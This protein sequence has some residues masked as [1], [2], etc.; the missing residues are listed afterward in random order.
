[1]AGENAALYDA[2]CDAFEAA[3]GGADTAVQR[4]IKEGVD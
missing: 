3:D 2:L 4:A 1:M